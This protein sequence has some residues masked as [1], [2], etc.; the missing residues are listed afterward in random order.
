MLTLQD[1]PPGYSLG[2]ESFEDSAGLAPPPGFTG[3]AAFDTQSLLG[4]YV[5][6]YEKDAMPSGSAM[7]LNIVFGC[8]SPEGAALGLQRLASM[9]GDPQ[10]NFDQLSMLHFGDETRAFRVD[11]ATPGTI[12]SAGGYV[13][14]FRKSNVVAGVIATNLSTIGIEDVVS[15]GKAMDA[16]IHPLDVPAVEPQ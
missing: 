1:L 13:V 7:I 15:M 16:K 12:L 8:K 5:R 6:Y 2:G 14:A 3:T 11:T 4:A 9:K 10:A